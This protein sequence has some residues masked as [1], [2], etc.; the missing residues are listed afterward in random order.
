MYFEIVGAIVHAETFATGSRIR[1]LARLQKR[2]GKGRWRKGI[3]RV[4]LTALSGSPKCIGMK[5]R[6]RKERDQD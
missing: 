4:R 6:D 3:A 5:R 2:Y 1:E